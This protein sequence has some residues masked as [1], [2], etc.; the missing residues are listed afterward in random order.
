M[1]ALVPLSAQNGSPAGGGSPACG[2]GQI[3]TVPLEG[4]VCVNYDDSTSADWD[5]A[6][7]AFHLESQVEPWYR[8]V[9]DMDAA[10]KKVIMRIMMTWNDPRVALAQCLEHP[11]AL[12]DEKKN[13]LMRQDDIDALKKA[14]EQAAEIAGTFKILIDPFNQAKDVVAGTHALRKIAHYLRSSTTVDDFARTYGP[15]PFK[16]LMEDLTARH[17]TQEIPAEWWSDDV[18]LVPPMAPTAPATDAPKEAIVY[19]VNDDGR[20]C[21][22]RPTT[23]GKAAEAGEVVGLHPFTDEYLTVTKVAH[24]WGLVAAQDLK[25]GTLFEYRHLR[26]ADGESPYSIMSI[27]GDMRCTF[28]DRNGLFNAASNFEPGELRISKSKNGKVTFKLTTKK[29]PVRRTKTLTNRPHAIFVPRGVWLVKPVKKGEEVTVWYDPRGARQPMR[30][31]VVEAVVTAIRGGG[32]S[33]TGPVTGQ[34]GRAHV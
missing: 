23:A 22:P 33:V 26:K 11:T 13:P 15:G 28:D 29:G 12:Y 7:T 25:P 16:T 10:R 19:R 14:A 6:M 17:V 20:V 18:H 3:A 1:T 5:P 30:E 27:K 21:D 4:D 34:I 2:P 24:G 9:A 8:R 32:G 31:K